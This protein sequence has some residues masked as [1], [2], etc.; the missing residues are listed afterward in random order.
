MHMFMNVYLYISMD[1]SMN[2]SMDRSMHIFIDISMGIM[3]IPLEASSLTSWGSLQG[4][5]CLRKSKLY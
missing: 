4:G 2:V 5:S 3:D 1:M